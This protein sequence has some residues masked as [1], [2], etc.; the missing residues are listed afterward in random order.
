MRAEAATAG[1]RQ[2]NRIALGASAGT[3]IEWFDFFLYGT[4]AVLVFDQ[5][6]FPGFSETAGTLAAL[7]TFTVG[8]LARPVGGLIFGHLGD[9]IGRK[10]MLITTLLIT[11]IATF[12]IGLLP[13][14]EQIGIW[15]PILL[16][17]MRILQGIGLGGEWGG[18]MLITLEHA[19][20]HRRGYYGSLP[21]TAAAFGMALAVLVLLISSLVSAEAFLT[22]GWRLPFLL[23]ILVL[24]VGLYFRLRVPESPEF[25]QVKKRHEQ[26]RVPAGELIRRHPKA[27]V[28]AIVVYFMESAPE[29]VLVV[30]LVSYATQ[31]VGISRDAVLLGIIVAHLFFALATVA[32]GALSDRIG[33]RPV[34][35][36]GAIFGA[37]MAFPLFWLTSTGNVALLWI[38]MILYGGGLWLTWGVIPA[39]FA[40]V[41]DPQV[42][43]TGL[44]L[45][46]QVSTTLVGGTAPLVAGVLFAATGATWAISSYVMVLVLMSATAAYVITADRYRPGVA[47]AAQAS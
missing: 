7:A 28:L 18:A 4:I 5:L 12:V 42:R 41:F 36:G 27:L 6:F 13:T 23:S 38:A 19:P 45:A 35:V 17:A 30:F 33:R 44:A 3:L 21:Q 34:L 20:S 31:T 16:V 11:G 47:V 46:S 24:A 39:L 32:G 43:Y 22:W 29:F 8:F 26:A 37:L 14:Y 9:K 25:E 15:A 2:M 40:E 1:P 10:T